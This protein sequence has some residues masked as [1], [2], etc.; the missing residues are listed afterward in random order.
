MFLQYA[1]VRQVVAS[2]CFSMAAESCDEP[3][4]ASLPLH[5]HKR[6]GIP[7]TLAKVDDATAMLAVVT[8]RGKFKAT[9]SQ[10]AGQHQSMHARPTCLQA[11]LT[12]YHIA[13]REVL[14]RRRLVSVP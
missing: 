12:Q 13:V 5:V 10:E 8:M 1:A 14:R 3:I 6:H 11:K 7:V 2:R 9:P 4:C